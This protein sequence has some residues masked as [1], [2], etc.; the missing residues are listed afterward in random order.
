MVQFRPRLTDPMTHH[1]IGRTMVDRSF[2]RE[3]NYHALTRQDAPR[4]AD[5]GTYRACCDALS[6]VV[7][8]YVEG[9][10]LMPGT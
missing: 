5:L 7:S 3:Q 9:G 2:F 10:W 6:H 4:R 1:Q 8:E